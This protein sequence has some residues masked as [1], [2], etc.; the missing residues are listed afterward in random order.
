IGSVEVSVRVEPHD[1]RVGCAR[2]DPELDTA[3]STDHDDRLRHA[4][5]GCALRI[6]HSN[7]GAAP[8]HRRAE[9]VTGLEWHLHHARRPGRKISADR[10]RTIDKTHGTR[11]TRPLPLTHDEEHR[12]LWTVGAR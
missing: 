8:R 11:R 6:P 1:R 3:V 4:D 12:R 5:E 2:S 9:L 7:E 10:F